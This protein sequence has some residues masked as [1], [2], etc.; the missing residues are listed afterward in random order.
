MRLEPDQ[1]GY[2]HHF[3]GSYEAYVNRYTNEYGNVFWNASVYGE[4]SEEQHNLWI[5]NGEI[6]YCSTHQYAPPR[7]EN[8]I[9]TE[10]VPANVS[11]GIRNAV[12]ES[13][14]ILERQLENLERKASDR[15]S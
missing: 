3:V 15:S 4:D 10:P 14:D 9:Y 1:R 2:G 6:F 12:R 5:D 7:G 8:L 11:D 13:I